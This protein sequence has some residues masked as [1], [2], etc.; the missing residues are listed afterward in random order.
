MSTPVYA[1]DLMTKDVVTLGENESLE[2]LDESMRALRFR[3]MP[4]TD[5]DRLVG[6]VSERDLLRT[7]AS[8]LLPQKH[9]QDHF[10]S[11]HFRVSAIMTR[12]VETVAPDAALVDVASMMSTRRLGCVPVVEKSGTLVGIITEADFV[13]LA[14]TLLPRP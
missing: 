6:L 13:R 12:D 5:G 8:S 1:R 4:V 14:Q 7:G 11:E 2:H 10:L 9:K 3:H